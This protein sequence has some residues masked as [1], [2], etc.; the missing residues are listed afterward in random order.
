MLESYPGFETTDA[1]TTLRRCMEERTSA[2][3][4]NEFAYADGS[5]AWF[6][7]RVQPVPEGL[8]ILSLDVT[9]RSKAGQKIRVQL[10][11]LR[12]WQEVML[13]REERVHTLKAEVNGL[14]AELRRLP[15]YG[16]PTTP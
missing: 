1:F 5:K 7:L 13:N 11:E 8:F 16:S 6:E 2:R 15:R 9:E 12:R 14:L 4:E 3:I 10:E